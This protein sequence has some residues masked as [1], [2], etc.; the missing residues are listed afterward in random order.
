MTPFYI[1]SEELKYLSA[2]LFFMASA[3]EFA[4]CL[5]KYINTFKFCCCKKD[6]ALFVFLLLLTSYLSSVPAKNTPEKSIRL[7]YAFMSVSAVLIFIAAMT[8]IRKEY[9]KSR[10]NISKSSIKA[11]FDNLNSGVC[12]ADASGKI[13]LI[14]KIMGKLISEQTGSFPQ[15]IAE[16][17]LAL[18]NNTQ[19]NSG[20]ETESLYRFSDGRVW[21]FRREVINKPS[22]ENYYQ[23]TSDDVTELYEASE[24]LKKENEKLKLT[25]E[26]TEKLYGRLSERI[27]EQETLNLKMRIHDE[28]GTSLIAISDILNGNDKGNTYEKLSELKNAVSYFSGNKP[29]EKGTFDEAKLKASKLNVKLTL[30]G[31]M[32]Y[33]T[34]LESIM[35]AAAKECVTN[36][37]RHAKGSRVDVCITEDANLYTVT[38]T[39]DGEI[40]KGKITEGGGLSSLRRRI[41]SAGGKMYISA[42]PRFALIIKYLK[43]E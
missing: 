15:T 26:K 4:L 9:R 20:I 7:P 43:N 24:Q 11:A 33:D 22:L 25:N 16:I 2:G 39:N 40:P 12:F 21:K 29:S 13:I 6:A 23:I 3:A 31:F 30:T 18:K 34:E 17:E 10:K 35:A 42:S 14:N 8:R 19:E 36:C 41:E 27:R 38:I 5:Y 1:V 37:V 32:P 28:I